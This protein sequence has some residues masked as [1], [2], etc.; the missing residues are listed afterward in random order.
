M[1]IMMSDYEQHHYDKDL[2]KNSA[3]NLGTLDVPVTDLE[4][5]RV[6]VNKHCEEQ[7]DSPKLSPDWCFI[8]CKFLSIFDLRTLQMFPLS[9]SLHSRAVLSGGPSAGEPPFHHRHRHRLHLRAGSG[10]SHAA[11]DAGRRERR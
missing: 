6:L 2:L 8:D 5:V 9:F 11:A 1:K 7:P 3:V 4:Q 10:V